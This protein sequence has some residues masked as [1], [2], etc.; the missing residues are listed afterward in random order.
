MVSI[1]LAAPVTVPPITAARLFTALQVPP[2]V[3]SAS[4]ISESAQTDERP[5]MVPAK[6]NGFIVTGIEATD[7]PQ[8]LVTE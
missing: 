3:P 6:G 7:V 4:V 1:P 8:E 5:L 2:A